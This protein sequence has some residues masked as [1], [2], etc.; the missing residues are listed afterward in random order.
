MADAG[1]EPSAESAQRHRGTLGTALPG[2]E[3]L[4]GKR[5]HRGS[6]FAAS[7][8]P[9]AYTQSESLPFPRAARGSF[10]SPPHPFLFREGEFQR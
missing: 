6:S 3:P 5:A 9:T 7:R 2:M 10:P 4:A 8:C 1:P